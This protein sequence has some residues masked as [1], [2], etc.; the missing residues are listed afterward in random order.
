VSTNTINNIIPGSKLD[1]I[2]DEQRRVQILHAERKS[3]VEFNLGA[4]ISIVLCNTSHPGN[5]GSVARAMKTMGLTNLIL[6]NP[7]VMPDDHS[8]A[9]ACNAAD[10]VDNAQILTSLDEALN[11]TTLSIAMTSRKREFT[12]SLS[13]PKQ[14]IPEIF[15]HINNGDKVAIVFGS[16]KNG[17]TIEQL[18]KC[19]RMV[20]IP[21]NQEYFS[22]N[23]AQA[24]QIMCYEIYSQ[25]D[26]SLEHLVATTKPATFADN[27]GILNHID[28]ILTNLN[29]YKN[30]NKERA[31]RRLQNIINKASLE[32]EDVDLIRG[33]L[34]NIETIL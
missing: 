22:L 28:N 19:N 31:V 34:K 25:H 5:I 10:V 16:E 9:L 4:G 21:G 29:F 12:H 14:I 8:R 7:T 3:K 33:L 30:R 32:R 6:V 23:L 20:T 27:Q 1:Y 17:L 2:N 11:D 18:E 13:T 26:S 24:V 15:M